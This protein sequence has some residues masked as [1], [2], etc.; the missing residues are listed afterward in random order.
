MTGV[1]PQWLLC[2]QRR[3]DAGTRLYVFPHS[4]GSPGEYVRWSDRLPGVEVHG[5]QAPGRGSRFREKPFTRLAELVEAIVTEVHFE[6][7]F[8]FFGHSLGGLVAYEASRQLRDR[9]SV[10]P[11]VLMVSSLDPPHRQ[12]PR[13]MLPPQ[14]SPEAAG[15]PEILHLAHDNL[16]ADLEALQSYVFTTATPLPCPLVV[17]GGTDDDQPEDISGWSG[18]GHGT[19]EFRLFPGGH[20]YHRDHHD[21]FFP[22]ILDALHAQPHQ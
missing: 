12:P 3:P 21:D 20:Y 11:Y 8:A 2:R 10:L 13:R 22:A 14:S 5:V 4:G 7:P 9:G 19:T 18:Y 6:P 15:R 1:A 17:F 16:Q